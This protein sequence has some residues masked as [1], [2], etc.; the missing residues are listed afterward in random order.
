MET[1]VNYPTNFIIFFSLMEQSE[2]SSLF[3]QVILQLTGPRGPYQHKPKG[4]KT[5]VLVFQVSGAM[6]CQGRVKEVS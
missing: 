6:T 5:S 4:A 3:L 1:S 2:S